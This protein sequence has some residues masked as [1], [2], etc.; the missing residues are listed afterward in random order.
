M[1]FFLNNEVKVTKSKLLVPTKGFVTG[2]Y[3]NVKLIPYQFDSPYAHF[4]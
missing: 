2:N 4:D 1:G 3:V